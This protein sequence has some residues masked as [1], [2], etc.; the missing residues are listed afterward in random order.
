MHATA[1]QVCLTRCDASIGFLLLLH[2]QVSSVA[3]R[4]VH[5]SMLAVGCEGGVA[6][7]SLGR[8][9]LAASNRSGGS[10]PPAA[11]WVTFLPFK[12]G[13]RVSSLS[14]SP[15]GRL[16]AGSSSDCNRMTVWDVA[17]GVGANLRLGLQ[18]VTCVLWSPDGNYLFAAARTGRFFMYETT[19]WSVRS[20][21]TPRGSAVTAAAW[22]PDSS[23][24]LLAMSNSSYLVALHL[25]GE[26]PKLIEQL[27]PIMLPGVSDIQPE[28]QPAGTTTAACIQSI[29]WDPTGNRLAVILGKPHPAA[30]TVA[31]YSTA[32]S[33]VVECKLIGYTQPGVADGAQA[34][35]RK[36]LADEDDSSDARADEWSQK[37][38]SRLQLAFA[39]VAG[40]AGAVLSMGLGSSDGSRALQLVR[41]VPMYF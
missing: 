38:Y 37:S 29:A 17:L 3:W 41:N 7:W 26:A 6:L 32:Y 8:L 13:C 34:H 39:P 5:S 12:K 19:T 10:G 4:P 40:K 22:A 20:W 9:P 23:V 25:V 31:L 2:V 11:G 33:P 21:D 27:L 28:D 16:L 14:W 35:Q 1:C 15:D 24:V 18:P 36:S 30:G